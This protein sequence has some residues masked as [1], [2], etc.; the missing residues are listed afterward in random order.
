MLYFFPKDEYPLRVDFQPNF[1][2]VNFIT[3]TCDVNSE[4]Y[5]KFCTIFLI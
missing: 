5:I 4:I 3:L 1:S 2:N